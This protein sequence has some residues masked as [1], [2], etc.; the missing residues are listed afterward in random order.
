MIVDYEYAN[1]HDGSPALFQ[2]LEKSGS[3]Q[4]I[5]VLFKNETLCGL[6]TAS[7]L[8]KLPSGPSPSNKVN[9]VFAQTAAAAGNHC[10]YG[11][12]LELLPIQ[13]PISAAGEVDRAD[14][15]R[16][17]AFRLGNR[18]SR[19]FSLALCNW[20]FELPIEQFSNS[21]IS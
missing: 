20:D 14:I 16:R 18:R 17:I 10:R 5:A 2:S 15:F 19:I 13:S 8:Q 9:P 3:P 21:A 6:G 1:C 4:C 11:L 7:R 12:P